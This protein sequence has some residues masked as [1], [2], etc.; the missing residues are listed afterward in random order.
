MDKEV[1]PRGMPKGGLKVAPMYPEKTL[2]IFRMRAAGAK[3]REI[4]AK[5]DHTPA[6]ILHYLIRWEKW[7]AEQKS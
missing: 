3:L 5:Y 6:G 2:E 4:A 1:K 7:A